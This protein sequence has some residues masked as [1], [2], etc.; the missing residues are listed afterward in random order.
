MNML[1]WESDDEPQGYRYLVSHHSG[2]ESIR[3]RTA[4]DLTPAEARTL[5]LALL[6]AAEQVEQERLIPA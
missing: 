5:A 2:S 3:V 6:T 4:D 1:K